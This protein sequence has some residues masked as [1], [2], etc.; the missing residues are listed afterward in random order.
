M[1]TLKFAALFA[2][3]A[4]FVAPAVA[5]DAISN[6]VTEAV[7]QLKSSVTGGSKEEG[8]SEEEDDEEG[9]DSEEDEG[10]EE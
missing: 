5:E 9:G 8:S 4:I 7:Q 6:P 3:L 1:I 10:A 2:T